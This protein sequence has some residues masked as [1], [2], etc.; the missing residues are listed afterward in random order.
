MNTYV[1]PSSAWSSNASFAAQTTVQL[2]IALD[3]A[4]PERGDAGRRDN[5]TLVFAARPLAA[6]D[7]RIQHLHAGE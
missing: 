1:L 7:G 2:N 5:V 6:T 3:N 4:G